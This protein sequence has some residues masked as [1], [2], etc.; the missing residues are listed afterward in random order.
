M[1]HKGKV[2]G[3]AWD[4]GSPVCVLCWVRFRQGERERAKGRSKRLGQR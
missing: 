3:L 2:E 4:G 1:L